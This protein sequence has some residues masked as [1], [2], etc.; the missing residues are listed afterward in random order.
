MTA[1]LPAIA[2]NTVTARIL[3]ALERRVDAADMTALRM[4]DLP[5][6]IRVAQQSRLLER[7]HLADLLRR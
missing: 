3:T 2:K 1:T 6:L 5:G 7:R 4:L